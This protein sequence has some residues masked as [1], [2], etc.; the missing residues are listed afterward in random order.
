[1]TLPKYCA[2]F[3]TKNNLSH[4][5]EFFYNLGVASFDDFFAIESLDVKSFLKPLEERRLFKALSGFNSGM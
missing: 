3:L 4:H 2:E 5:E 1:M